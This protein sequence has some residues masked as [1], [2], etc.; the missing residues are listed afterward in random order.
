MGNSFIALILLIVANAL[1]SAQAA[2]NDA[3]SDTKKDQP[4]QK[5]AEQEF[6]NI[7]SLKG[8][9]ADQVLPTMQFFTASLGVQCSFCHV[10]SPAFAP[11]K[12]DKKE[13]V[14]A[15]AMIA[16]V[17]EI[18]KDN[19]KG[20]TQVGCATCHAG[21]NEPVPVPP[22]GD[23]RPKQPQ[24]NPQ[25]PPPTADQVLQSYFTAVGGKAALEKLTTKV[26]RGNVTT[27]IGKVPFE[28]DQKAPGMFVVS[29]TLPNGVMYAEGVNATVAW[30]K[31][32]REATDMSGPDTAM[33][34]AGARFF[35]PDLAPPANSVNQRV[36][37]AIVNGHDC[38]SLR[39][40]V[41]ESGLF[42]RLDFDRQSGL[43]LRRT[44][45]QRT[46][47]GPLPSQWDYSDYR[48]V[49]GVKVPFTIVRGRWDGTYVFTADSV[50]LNVP[51]DDSRFQ[52]PSTSQPPKP[53]GDAK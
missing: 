30:R 7:Q 17:N 16:M 40:T 32:G 13:K 33:A 52:K 49:N 10:D 36:G 19:F 34:K 31:E 26:T 46:L 14:T 9:P 47:F 11:E 28:V 38:Y 1:A 24:R 22:L 53:R 41:P 8:V 51:L 3:K 48:D 35:D 6:K 45:V 27:P 42:E 2:G 23:D 20:R 25:Q 4:A 15:R 5:T 37:L 43:L 21:R 50:Q 18:N 12:D 39:E 44:I 29:V